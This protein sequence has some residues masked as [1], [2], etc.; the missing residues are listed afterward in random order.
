MSDETPEGSEDSSHSYTCGKKHKNNRNP[1][2]LK[3]FYVLY[4]VTH[5][6]LIPH[7]SSVPCHLHPGLPS[8][9]KGG[10]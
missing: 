1:E 4:F 10:S 6:S 8:A 2:G 3:K 7:T 5:T 9:A